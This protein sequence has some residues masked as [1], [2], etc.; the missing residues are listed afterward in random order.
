MIATSS[1]STH[2]GRL[3]SRK[4]IASVSRQRSP[5]L[6]LSSLP[7][8]S[9]IPPSLA[10]STMSFSLCGERSH[11]TVSKHTYQ[12]MVDLFQ[13]SKQKQQQ[14]GKLVIGQD[15]VGE[16]AT[17]RRVF[18]PGANAQ[19]L[20]TSGGEELAQNASFDPNYETSKDWIR[21][22]AVGPAV[23]SS[24]LI[25]GLVGALIEASFP[26]TVPVNA[27][28][29]FLRPLIVGMEVA[30][31]IEVESIREAQ[32]DGKPKGGGG[33]D[34]KTATRTGYEIVLSTRVIRV[35]DDAV[36]AKGY[37]TVWIPGYL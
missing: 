30:A 16:K 14:G 21:S 15:F 26:Q 3:A 4:L 31:C 9:M 29:D 24:T 36:I 25:S 1:S 19:A 7:S 11:S 13:S 37:S 23:L 5:V 10:P 17:I 2:L 28:M 27:S 12:P 34:N 6:A 32:R 22:R 8:S 33:R 20:L 18:G 35:Q